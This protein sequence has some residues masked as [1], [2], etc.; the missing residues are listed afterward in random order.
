M[1]PPARPFRHFFSPSS[2]PHGEHPL[3]PSCAISSLLYFSVTSHRIAQDVQHARYRAL[4]QPSQGSDRKPFAISV[5]DPNS[6]PGPPLRRFHLHTLHIPYIYQYR[7][8][9]GAVTTSARVISTQSVLQARRLY[10]PPNI[11]NG[12][13]RSSAFSEE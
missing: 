13:L 10:H 11:G 6:T 8:I 5:R 9:G 12:K 2:P 1:A 3:Y 7:V 4:V